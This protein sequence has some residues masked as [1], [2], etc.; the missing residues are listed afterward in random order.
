MEAM[1]MSWNPLFQPSALPIWVL[2]EEFKERRKEKDPTMREITK[3]LGQSNKMVNSRK[4]TICCE[5]IKE[6]YEREQRISTME[7]ACNSKH[8]EWKWITTD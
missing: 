7:E 1:E 3:K 2:A 5:E 6:N 8:K 4:K